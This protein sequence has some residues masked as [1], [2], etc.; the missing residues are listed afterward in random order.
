[1]VE[2]RPVAQGRSGVEPHLAAV[3]QR[4]AAVGSLGSLYGEQLHGG[5]GVYE[6][7]GGE[8]RD[9][10]E[11]GCCGREPKPAAAGTDSVFAPFYFL[12]EQG[13]RTEYVGRAACAVVSTPVPIRASGRRFPARRRGI[14][15]V[16]TL[17]RGRCVLRNS[18][19]RVLS[20]FRSWGR[21]LY[22]YINTTTGADFTPPGSG[23]NPH[24]F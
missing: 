14:R 20:G 3:G 1:M 21:L 13:E 9:Q 5:F 16:R 6:I 18:G 7:P 8:G 10:D 12:V 2:I 15:R 23:K 22:A 17:L 24:I 11:Y 4:Y 19:R